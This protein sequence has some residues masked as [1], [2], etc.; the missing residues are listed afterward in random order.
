MITTDQISPM[1]RKSSRLALPKI[2]RKRSTYTERTRQHSRAAQ[3][4]LAAA[5]DRDGHWTH[6]D[7]RTAMLRRHAVEL[8]DLLAF[9]LR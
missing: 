4:L 6:D 8:D 2:A 7:I 5:N 9:L 3:T 1:P